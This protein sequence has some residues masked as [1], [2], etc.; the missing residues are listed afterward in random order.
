MSNMSYCRF[1]NTLSD[2]QDCLEKL[3]CSESWDELGLSEREKRCAIEMEDVA[4][5][6]SNLLTYL[7]ENAEKCNE[8]IRKT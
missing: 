2:M 1:E 8:T 4:H 3:E 5:E 6:I 7:R